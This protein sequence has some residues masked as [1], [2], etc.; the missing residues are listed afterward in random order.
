MSFF[1]LTAFGPENIIKS[2]RVNSNCFTL[3][4]DEDFE[5]GFKK[6]T[7]DNLHLSQIKDFLQNTFNI[8]P[9]DDE[10]KSN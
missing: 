5:K 8:T 7:K 3:F 9:L 1:G 4:S 6:T 10:I 2:S